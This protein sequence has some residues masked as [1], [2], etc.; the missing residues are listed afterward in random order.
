MFSIPTPPAASVRCVF[1]SSIWISYLGTVLTHPE[2]RFRGEWQET[3]GVDVHI[4][5][6]HVVFAGALSPNQP[7]E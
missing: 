6:L 4:R 7:A 2:I 5:E 1:Q 3:F